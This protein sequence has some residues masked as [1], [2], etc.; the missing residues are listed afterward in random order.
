MKQ[1]QFSLFFMLSVFTEINKKVGRALGYEKFLPSRAWLLLS[2]KRST[3]YTS[4]YNVKSRTFA[5]R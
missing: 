5:I 2:K 3:F 4:L 1:N